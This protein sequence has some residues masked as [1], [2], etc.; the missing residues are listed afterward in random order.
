VRKFTS[1]I[2]IFPNTSGALKSNCAMVA[3]DEVIAI[4]SSAGINRPFAAV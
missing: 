3:G 4:H 2:S 1:K